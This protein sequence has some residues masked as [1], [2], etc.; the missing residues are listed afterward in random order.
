MSTFNIASS[1]LLN[2]INDL[3]Y[4]LTVASLNYK[5][6]FTNLQY[7]YVIKLAKSSFYQLLFQL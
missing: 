4:S 6:T 3:K 7:D 1:S 5:N 2:E